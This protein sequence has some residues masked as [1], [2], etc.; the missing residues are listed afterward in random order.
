M[1]AN[2]SYDVA[3]GGLADRKKLH[4]SI[5]S[6]TNVNSTHDVAGTQ[7]KRGIFE[8][9]PF[10]PEAAPLC[11]LFGALYRDDT[12]RDALKRHLLPHLEKQEM[13][14]QANDGVGGAFPRSAARDARRSSS[15]RVKAVA[16]GFEPH[17]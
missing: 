4:A 1:R 2:R 12:L 3:A 5:A 15:T 16:S 9:E 7:V 13:R 10:H 17:R 8:G 11:P 6:A 14:L